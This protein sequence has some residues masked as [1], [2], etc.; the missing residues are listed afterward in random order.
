MSGRNPARA[1]RR[2]SSTSGS[3][4]LPR[5]STRPAASVGRTMELVIL[6]REAGR[7]SWRSGARA[8]G[9][10]RLGGGPLPGRGGELDRLLIEARLG[11][12]PDG[13]LQIDG[14]LR[15]IGRASLPK[16]IESRR[17]IRRG[18]VARHHRHGPQ[19][20]IAELGE[21]IGRVLVPVI[22]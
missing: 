18:R 5:K 3:L 13:K 8:G 16:L 20:A 2:P 15:F 14:A 21:E 10:G 17:V 6:E 1:W 11:Q 22:G 4:R 9:H 12:E 7:W 19:R